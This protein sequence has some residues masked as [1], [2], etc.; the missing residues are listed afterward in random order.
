VLIRGHFIALLVFQEENEFVESDPFIRIIPVLVIFGIF[1][2]EIREEIGEEL[3]FQPIR[4]LQT[5]IPEEHKSTASLPWKIVTKSCRPRSPL[6][7]A[8]IGL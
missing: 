3:Q 6:E 4:L 8:S 7:A 1:L 2:H 5:R